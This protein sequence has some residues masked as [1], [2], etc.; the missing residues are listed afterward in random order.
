MGAPQ[1]WPPLSKRLKPRHRGFS[2]TCRS[3]PPHPNPL[4]HNVAELAF[5]IGQLFAAT[6]RGRGGF[7]PPDLCITM[8]AIAPNGHVF[9]NNGE[10]RNGNIK[11]LEDH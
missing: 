8:M 10:V 6:L 3:L 2:L 7:D 9:V 11:R 1:A 4:P 5:A